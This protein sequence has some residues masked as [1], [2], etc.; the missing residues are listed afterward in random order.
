[1]N[2]TTVLSLMMG[3]LYC[4]FD[5]HANNLTLYL[6][7]IRPHLEYALAVWD[8]HQQGLINSL[9]RVQKLALKM[10]TKN[11]IYSGN[12]KKTA[13]RSVSYIKSSM[14]ILF[15]S[16]EPIGRQNMP[17]NLSNSS[18]LYFRGLLFTQT[19]TCFHSFHTPFAL[20]NTLPPAQQWVF[21][22]FNIQYSVTLTHLFF[23]FGYIVS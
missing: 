7:Y 16:D 2:S 10:C 12:Q 19:T 18:T 4:K 1:M 11:L 20:W 21:V 3:I 15:F 14:V 8:L 22:S 9:E 23:L 6:A 5:H 13:W 17:H